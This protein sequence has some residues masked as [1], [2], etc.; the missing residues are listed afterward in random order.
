[1]CRSAKISGFGR[2]RASYQK[3][4]QNSGI[5]FAFPHDI[6]Q[7]VWYTQKRYNIWGDAMRYNDE[8]E[9]RRAYY[10]R[11]RRKR[12]QQLIWRMTVITLLVL[13]LILLVILIGRFFISRHNAKAKTVEAAAPTSETAAVETEPMTI[14]DEKTVAIEKLLK[15]AEALAVTYDYDG[16]ID[17]LRSDPQYA[18]DPAVTG[19]V[20]SYEEIK[21]TLVRADVNTIPH[22]FFHSLIMDNKKAFDGDDDQNGYNQVMTTKSEFLKILEQMYERGYVLVRIHDMAYETTNEEGKTVMKPGNIMLPPGKKPFVMSQDDVC[23]YDYMTGDGFATRMV[24]GEDGKP[25]CEMTLDDGTVSVGSYDMVPLLEDFIQE[26]PDFSYKGAR[27]IIAFTGYQGILGYRTDPD[28]ADKNPNIEADKEAVKEVV[29]SLRDNG[30]ELASHT[31][32]HMRLSTRSLSDIKTD[33][34]KWDRYVVPLLGD[35]DILI[36]PYGADI[37]DWHPYTRDNEKF[38]FLYDHGFR[39]FCNVDSIKYWVQLGAAHLRQARRNL[40]GERMY[41]DLPEANPT[42]DHLSDL[43][44]VTEVFDRD[45]PVPV[46]PSS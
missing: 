25:T 18:G 23:Y 19:A 5:F 1:M 24:V 21:S 37:G 26:H 20:A 13:I 6:P 40:D 36:Y 9:R 39:Y 4:L 41:Y 12:R 42:K 46:P 43:F 14:V 11:R 27:A 8:Y 38:A 3:M 2:P 7:N 35:V 10:E 22:V 32:G 15:D 30:W 16:A 45:R 34:G 33:T 29:K 28:Y 17:L 31:Y 44:D